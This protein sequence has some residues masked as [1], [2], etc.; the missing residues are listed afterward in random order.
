MI[1]FKINQRRCEA[2]TK[3]NGPEAGKATE[4][5]RK[6]ALAQTFP[7]ERITLQEFKN[8]GPKNLSKKSLKQPFRK[9]IDS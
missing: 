5:K 7:K 2:Q 1:D 8:H 6:N 4:H 9:M 3:L